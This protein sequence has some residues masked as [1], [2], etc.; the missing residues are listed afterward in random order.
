MSTR[1]PK[2][3]TKS[4]FLKKVM[5]RISFRMLVENRLLFEHFEPLDHSP[6][7]PYQTPSPQP[8]IRLGLCC[9]V[10]HCAALTA[11]TTKSGTY[12]GL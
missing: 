10:G 3:R 9:C 12:G 2:E 11:Q 8:Q 5:I 1:T 6:H 4:G 7:P